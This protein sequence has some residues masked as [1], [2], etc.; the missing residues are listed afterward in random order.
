MIEFAFGRVP[1]RLKATAQQRKILPK[2]LA[3]K[4]FPPGFDRHRK[5]G[6]SI[7]LGTWLAGGEWRDYFH[8]V[9]LGPDCLFDRKAVQRLL[10]GQ[11][12]GRH[13]QERL[14]AL[15][16]FELWRREYHMTL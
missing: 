5:Q 11:E 3:A 9:L 2:R 8:A 13:N 14:F 1:A 12:R 7:P 15:V 4:L 10:K 16:L 6:F